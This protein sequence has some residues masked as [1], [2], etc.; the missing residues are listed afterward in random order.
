M[1]DRTLDQQCTVTRPA[2]S[3]IAGSL[4]VE[5]LIA[6]IHH[7]LASSC[8]AYISL[9]NAET[10]SVKNATPEGIL[11]IVPHSIR[12][13]ISNYE[14]IMPATERFNNC[15]A[16]SKVKFIDKII[17][18]GDR[19]KD[20]SIFIFL[21]NRKLSMNTAKK[22]TSFSSKFSSRQSV[23]RTSLVFRKF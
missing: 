22:V 16:C 8:P 6:L 4:A 10:N 15:V 7:P 17:I 14:Q 21:Q 13:W 5:L 1:T 11:G 18:I 23:W 12:G 2:V 19:P 3:N 9:G 20:N